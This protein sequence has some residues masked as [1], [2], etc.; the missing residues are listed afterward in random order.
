MMMMMMMM[1]MMVV[2]TVWLCTLNCTPLM[3]MP[4]LLGVCMC[5]CVPV[6]GLFQPRCAFAIEQRSSFAHNVDASPLYPPPPSRAPSLWTRFIVGEV[7][8]GAYIAPRWFPDAIVDLALQ[9]RLQRGRQLEYD[10]AVAIY[11]IAKN[12][13]FPGIRFARTTIIVRRY[14]ELVADPSEDAYRAYAAAV[15]V[16]LSPCLRFHLL[17]SNP[18]KRYSHFRSSLKHTIKTHAPF[19]DGQVLC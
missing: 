9:R 4:A 8:S 19:G 18:V 11:S 6:R 16:C 1:A 10:D 14:F 7:G 2:L 13:F 5:V 15:C 17:A 12:D 3:T